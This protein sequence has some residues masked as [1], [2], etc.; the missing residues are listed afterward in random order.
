VIFAT[1]GSHLLKG[2]DRQCI[3]GTLEAGFSLSEI[4][5][6]VGFWR[7]KVSTHAECLRMGVPVGEVK[8][9]YGLLP[10]IKPAALKLQEHPETY[11]NEMVW[12]LFD[13]HNIIASPIT[14]WRALHRSGWTR[15]MI[16][17]VAGQR[18]S[19]FTQRLFAI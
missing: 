12:Y 7:Q 19:D 6:T 15:K 1:T 13:G 3:G 9:R 10:L 14:T 4:S 5:R 8:H 17:D 16:R 2:G 11:L 18:E